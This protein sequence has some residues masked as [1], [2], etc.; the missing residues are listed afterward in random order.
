MR[1]ILETFYITTGDRIITLFSVIET[2]FFPI[3]YVIDDNGRGAYK[4]HYLPQLS[5]RDN[6]DMW[7]GSI[8]HDV[9]CAVRGY[10]QGYHFEGEP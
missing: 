6:L 10:W 8:Q 3:I 4:P 7:L 1:A 9:E 2:L 5:F